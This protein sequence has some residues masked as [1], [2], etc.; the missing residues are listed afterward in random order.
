MKVRTNSSFNGI[1]AGVAFKNG[2]GETD[3]PRIL[4]YFRSRGYTVGD[5]QPVQ[6]SPKMPADK[7]KGGNADAGKG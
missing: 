1:I 4:N 6:S 7:V 3:D 2:V 5:Q